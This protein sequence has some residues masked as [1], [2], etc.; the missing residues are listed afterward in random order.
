MAK[1]RHT[2][3]PT[4]TPPDTSDTQAPAPGEDAPLPADPGGAHGKGY[5]A[6]TGPEPV[7]PDTGPIPL[8]PDEEVKDH[9]RKPDDGP[10]L[11]R[12]RGH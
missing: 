11:S 9:V 4:S 3:R 6:E 10:G 12:P 7:I 8:V 1:R 2:E 5:C